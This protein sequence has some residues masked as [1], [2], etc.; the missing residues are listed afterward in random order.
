MTEREKPMATSHV[1]AVQKILVIDDEP[2]ICL[3]FKHLLEEE[4][5]RVQV[6][7]NGI[8]GM[9]IVREWNPDM[10]ITDLM[11]PEQDGFHTIREIRKSNSCMP[12]IAMSALANPADVEDSMKAGA[13]CYVSKPVDIATLLKIIENMSPSG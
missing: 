1:C 4:G 11:M 8:S 6:A 3:T 7:D 2:S 10:V 5:Y 13:L 12:I 9:K